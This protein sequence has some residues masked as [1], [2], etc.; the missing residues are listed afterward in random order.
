MLCHLNLFVRSFVQNSGI[1]DFELRLTVGPEACPN[2]SSM[3]L[4]DK[5]KIYPYSG[6][7]H[8]FD[9]PYLGGIPRWESIQSDRPVSL[10]VDVDTVVCGDL[11]D[12][13]SR[14]ASDRKVLGVR[15]IGSPFRFMAESLEN[16]RK[17][18]EAFAIR[19]RYVDHLGVGVH[20]HF[21]NDER[22]YL[23]P[24]TYFNYGFVLVPTDFAPS[25]AVQLPD[26]V[27]T[28]ERLFPNNFW[29]GEI[30]LCVVLNILSLPAETIGLEYNFPDRN[31]FFENYPTDDIRLL[32]MVKKRISS[33]Q[34]IQTLL[35]GEQ[36]DRVGCFLSE[37][38]RKIYGKWI[39]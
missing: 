8:G 21:G 28:C 38:L 24:D 13:V 10:L 5:L 25:I 35:V 9:P 18:E 4:G 37:Q 1:D 23:I 22:H 11:S 36:S 20:E 33:K 17:V 2:L 19:F 14:C 30:A 27:K 34:D 3:G 39:F 32:H 15:N 26:I 16:W 31:E 6:S 12:V 29:N 7:E